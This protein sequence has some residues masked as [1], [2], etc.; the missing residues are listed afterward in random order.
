MDHER[1]NAMLRGEGLRIGYPGRTL[2][3]QAD[4]EL[5][6]GSFTA[7]LGLNGSGKSTLLR[8]LAGLQAPLAG[9]ILIAGDRQAGLSARERARRISVVLPGRPRTGSMTARELVGLGRQPW[10][11]A[12]GASAADEAAVEEALRSA[13]AIAHAARPFDSLSDG[14]AQ[15]VLIARALAQEAPC[16]LLDEPTAHLDLVNRVAVMRLLAELAR[17]RARAVLVATHD[18]ALAVELCD[19]LMLV[20]EGSLW[21]G[22]TP[23][24]VHGGVLARV[25]EREGVSLRAMLGA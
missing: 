20:H 10:Q 15:R 14:E 11:G 5:G 8:T 12:F 23:D 25:F 1:M 7:L 17:S 4:F 6:R 19:R 21:A 18:L 9:R 3:E 22:A 13:G 2:L 16:L 24:A